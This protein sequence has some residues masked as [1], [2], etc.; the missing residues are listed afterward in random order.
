M[1]RPAPRLKMLPPLLSTRQGPAK[2]PGWSAQHTTSSTSRGYGY[3]WQKARER[4][5]LRDC[6]LCVPCRDQGRTTQAQEVDHIVPKFEGGGDDELN[7]QAICDDCHTV[8]TAAESK[9]ARGFG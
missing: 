1:G 7:L 6:G 2:A 3:S 5:L 9:R 4:V 8:K